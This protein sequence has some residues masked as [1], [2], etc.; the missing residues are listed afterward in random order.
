MDINSVF[1][2][3]RRASETADQV[4]Y[5]I[6]LDELVVGSGEKA[7]VRQILME[8][9]AALLNLTQPVTEGYIWQKD[10]F[11]LRVVDAPDVGPGWK[12]EEDGQAGQSSTAWGFF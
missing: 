3:A 7:Q 10:A 8:R 11:N 1:D 12:V 2:G 5:A 9:K 6:F 4:E